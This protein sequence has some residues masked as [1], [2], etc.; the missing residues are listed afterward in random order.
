[1]KPYELF[2]VLAGKTW[3]SIER[4]SRNRI[5]LGEDAIT[6]NNLDALAS[7]GPACVFLED[8][9]AQESTKGCDF[10]LWIGSSY[11]GWRRY[12]V[13]AKKIQVSS[14]RYASLAHEVSGVLQIDILDAYA[15]ANRALALY[16]FYNHSTKPYNWNCN[17]APE[18]EQLGCS[19]TPSRVVR[20]AIAKHGAR[21][22]THL[23]SQPETLPWRC[24]LR[25]PNFVSKGAPGHSGWPSLAENFYPQLPAALQR[26]RAQGGKISFEDL[27]ELFNSNIQFRP[28]WVGVVD[29]GGQSR[30]GG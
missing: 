11:L 2:E 24:L 28:Q 23:H 14:S 20:A 8:T 25:C 3:R 12:A 16:C 27:P 4:F 5:H 30:D 22:Y 7:A 10:E 19:V 29:V 18:L 9:R 17:L 15:G 21:N 6:S 13:Q 26:L 1:M